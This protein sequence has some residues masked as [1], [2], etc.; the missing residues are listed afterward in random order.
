MQCYIEPKQGL[1]TGDETSLDVILG[2]II[3]HDIQNKILEFLGGS[4]EFQHE[5]NNTSYIEFHDKL[6]NVHVF[7]VEDDELSCFQK[8][9]I[10]DDY[11]DDFILGEELYFKHCHKQFYR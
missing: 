6:L 8:R 5:D 4:D 11:D 7:P 10:Y 1:L 9:D 3:G 2:S